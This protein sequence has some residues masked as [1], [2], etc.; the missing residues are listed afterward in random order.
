MLPAHRRYPFS[1]IADRPDSEC[2]EHKRLAFYIATNLEHFALKARR[3]ER[4][5]IAAG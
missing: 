5:S 3:T 1:H 4:V 2:P